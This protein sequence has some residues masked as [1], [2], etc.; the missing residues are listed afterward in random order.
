M[1]P[2]GNG[3]PDK[4]V[5]TAYGSEVRRLREE[6]GF[7]QTAL[8][9][10]AKSSKTTI[11]DVE[12]G[13]VTPSPQLRAELDEV[14]GKGRLSHLW[15]E[16]TVSDGEIWKYEIAEMIDSASAVYEYEVLVFPAYLQTEAYAQA[17]IRQGAPWLPSAEVTQL[18][19]ERWKRSQRLAEAEQPKLWVVLDGAVLARRYGGPTVIAEQLK[20]VL[21]LVDHDRVSLQLVPPEEPR[22]PGVSGAYKLI[23]TEH[24]PDVLVAESIREG[25]VVTNALEVAHYRMQFAALQGVALGPA[26]TLTR[27]REEIKGLES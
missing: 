27:L 21:R 2:N 25:H 1:A 14:L 17:I 19:Q 9:R 3:K 7:T 16:L 13:R 10:R 23:T 12:R 4:R 11:S 8:A 18:A 5:C 6:A 22:H 24:A 15:K 20:H 26:E